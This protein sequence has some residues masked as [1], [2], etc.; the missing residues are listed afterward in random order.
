MYVLQN[1]ANFLKYQYSQITSSRHLCGYLLRL[2]SKNTFL[3]LEQKKKLY[4]VLLKKIFMYALKKLINYH[5]IYQF[6]YSRFFKNL[7]RDANFFYL[8]KK[9]LLF[10]SLNTESKKN[11]DRMRL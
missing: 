3:K 10:F 5:P 7:L 11:P 8:E 1:I 9:S 6:V 2:I 4:R